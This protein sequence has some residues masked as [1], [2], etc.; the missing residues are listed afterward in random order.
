MDID[1]AVVLV[2]GASS[3]IGAATAR[4][5][6]A[7]GADVVLLGRRED[8]LRELAAELGRALPVPCDVT[9]RAQVEAAVQAAIDA[10]GR[11]D[12]LVNN[13]GQGLQATVDR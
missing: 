8:R 5:A 2:T 11:I 10:Y 12:V 13:A 7:A 9:E 3:G 4:A 1:N 6:S